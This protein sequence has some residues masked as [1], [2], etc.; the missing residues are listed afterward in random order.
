MQRW[1]WDAQ[2]RR[3]AAVGRRACE[4]SGKSPRVRRDWKRLSE[5][6]TWR[7]LLKRIS[8][9]WS[10]A[11]LD[12][13]ATSRRLNT[14]SFLH[15]IFRGKA[16]SQYDLHQMCRECGAQVR[17]AP[18][19][20]LIHTRARRFCRGAAMAVKRVKAMNQART[21]RT[22]TS[23]KGGLLGPRTPAR[24]VLRL[25][26]RYGTADAGCAALGKPR[27]NG[28]SGNTRLSSLL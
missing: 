8:D 28:A 21:A 7:N 4:A 15:P 6:P 18:S 3:N 26:I 10:S 5:S 27:W 12:F 1:S 9:S 25:S 11:S 17:V 2:G 19:C 13:N 14:S 20:A 23:V 24:L 22:R 16:P